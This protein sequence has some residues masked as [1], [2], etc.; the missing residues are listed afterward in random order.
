QLKIDA[1]NYIHKLK[2]QITCKL[3]FS[4]IKCE[5]EDLEFLEFEYCHL[6][7]INR[8]YKYLSVKA[9]LHQIPVTKT[10]VTFVLMKRLNG[11]KP[12][13]YNVTIDGCKFLKNPKA[14]PIAKFLYDFFRENSNMNHCCPYNHDIILDRLPTT[15]LN[16]QLTN[17]LPFPSGDYLFHTRWY[18][19]DKIRAIVDV[20]FSF[21]E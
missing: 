3:E 13:L 7:S 4:N 21:I 14:N 5:S 20:Y 15:H 17:V 16:H 10:K 1:L 6:K 12:F 18:A 2:Q 8:T 11:Y 19:Y 9:Q